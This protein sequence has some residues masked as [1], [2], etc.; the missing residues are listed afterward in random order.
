[1][2]T[3]SIK[4]LSRIFGT[5]ARE[6]KGIFQAT[7][8]ELLALPENA[9]IVRSSYHKP[10]KWVLRLNALNACGGFYGIE[11]AETIAGEFMSYL[12]AGEMYAETVIYWRGRYRVQTVGDFVETMERNRVK[13]K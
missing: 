1:M 5:G 6:A 3:P 7:G 13:F 11:H 10:K 4:T 2:K 12:N 9:E 8:A